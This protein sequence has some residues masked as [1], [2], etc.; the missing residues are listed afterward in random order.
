MPI[1]KSHKRIELYLCHCFFFSLMD[2]K[3]WIEK[4][5]RGS[6]LNCHILSGILNFDAYTA[7]LKWK[8]SSWNAQEENFCTLATSLIL[9]SSANILSIQ[10][11]LKQSEEQRT[12]LSSL[13]NH[14]AWAYSW[15]EIW[16]GHFNVFV[17]ILVL[18]QY[19]SFLI[20]ASTFG[21]GCLFLFKS[22]R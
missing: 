7:W 22:W 1:I 19:F 8:N 12:G 15:R 13:A 10:K 4:V 20:K 21:G 2:R 6:P 18:L 9:A 16:F 5:R 17:A 14:R 3:G 11:G